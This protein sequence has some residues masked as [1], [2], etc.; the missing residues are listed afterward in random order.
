MASRTLIL[1]PPP[2]AQHQHQAGADA[3]LNQAIH[4]IEPATMVTKNLQ[5]ITGWWFQLLWNILVSWDDYSQYME[6]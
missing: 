6:K 3:S 1:N 4:L 2:D 5:T